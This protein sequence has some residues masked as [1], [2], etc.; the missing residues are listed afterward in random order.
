[1]V[2]SVASTKRS[3]ATDRLVLNA[4]L[5]ADGIKAELDGARAAPISAMAATANF[6]VKGVLFSE[7]R[8]VRTPSEAAT[9]IDESRES[10]VGLPS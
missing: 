7:E 8:Y 5:L 3:L 1:M 10:Y 6:M 9:G 4:G 2:A